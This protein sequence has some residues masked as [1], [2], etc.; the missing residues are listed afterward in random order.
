MA[1][2]NGRRVVGI[3]PEIHERLLRLS[4]L[5]GKTQLWLIDKFSSVYESRWKTRMSAEEWAR[6]MADDISPAEARRIMARAEG[7]DDDA[8]RIPQPFVFNNA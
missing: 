3:N 1:T 2:T 6:Y 8:P 5:H 4:R 7:D